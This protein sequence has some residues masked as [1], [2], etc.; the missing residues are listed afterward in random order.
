MKGLC[1]LG[2]G[3]TTKDLLDL[4]EW[5]NRE[6][7][8][9][10]R[11]RCLGIL[12]DD[13]AL[14]GREYAGVPVLGGLAD[15]TSLDADIC[16]AFAIGSPRTV[17]KRKMIFERLALDRRRFPSFIHPKAVVEKGAAI[18]FGTIIF[19]GVVV[20]GSATLG[21]FS[22]LLANSVVN[23][24]AVLGEFVCLASGVC[25][26][27]D[28]AIGDGVYIGANASLRDGVRIGEDTLIGLG[29][30]VVSSIPSGCTAYGVPARIRDGS[31]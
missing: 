17:G 16:F 4:I 12:D 6:T 26:S 22:I 24:D 25:V 11:W 7:S 29:S 18:G 2:A 10:D 9:E 8:S 15:A 20:S 31:G 3:G 27:G 13:R 30:V 28:V 23:H 1:I 14:H 21:P 5:K 19:P